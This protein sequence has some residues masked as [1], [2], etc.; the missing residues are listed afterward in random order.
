MVICFHFFQDYW[1]L[2]CLPKI[3]KSVGTRRLS[4]SSI[5]IVFKTIGASL[6]FKR[7]SSLL[8]YGDNH[9]LPLFIF[10]K[11]LLEFLVRTSMSSFIFARLPRLLLTYLMLLMLF[12]SQ[13]INVIWFKS[14][15]FE[16]VKI[17][18]LKQN[19][20]EF[21]SSRGRRVQ[22]YN[23]SIFG[24]VKLCGLSSASWFILIIDND[25]CNFLGHGEFL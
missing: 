22:W 16:L 19:Q 15:T 3:C 8:A 7:Q 14:N 4:W 6:A 1:S 20:E 12:P 11:S 23:L 5:F 17:L 18:K 9:G 2:P 24:F 25:E 10:L 21:F 13:K